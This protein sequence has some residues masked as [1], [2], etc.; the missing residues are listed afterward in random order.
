MTIIND[1][2]ALAWKHNDA[3][4]ITAQFNLNLLD[5]VG[6]LLGARFEAERF[7]H[8]ASYNA[9][10]G[11]IQM[12]LEVLTAHEVSFDGGVFRFA[13]SERVHTENSFKYEPEEFLSV[14]ASAGYGKVDMWTDAAGRYALFLLDVRD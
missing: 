10:L 13:E 2:D 7:R 4:G 3:A 14:A 1:S 6:R 12:F 8:V 9:E 11:C 5:H